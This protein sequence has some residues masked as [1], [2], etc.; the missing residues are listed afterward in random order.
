MYWLK[1]PTFVGPKFNNTQVQSKG[2]WGRNRPVQYA[3]NSSMEL[4]WAS[5]LLHKHARLLNY[6]YLFIYLGGGCWRSC[7]KKNK[8]EE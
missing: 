1:V 8:G 5:R 2:I 4:N 6:F 7:G 3:T